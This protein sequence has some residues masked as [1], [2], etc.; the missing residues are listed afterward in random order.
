MTESVD[1][2]ATADGG[3]A[4]RAAESSSS[5]TGVEAMETAS[6]RRAILVVLVTIGLCVAAA[7]LVQ[8]HVSHWLK[9]RG[10]YRNL[11]HQDENERVEA[12]R[13]LINNGEN[14][15]QA[16][17]ALLSHSNAEVRLFAAYSLAR[18]RPVTN[19][20]IDL[21]LTDLE[22][23]SPSEAIEKFAT[24]LFYRHA[25]Q[26]T[27]PLT[28]TEQRMIAWLRRQLPPNDPDG[29]SAATAF[30][31]AT[32]LQRDPTLMK[33]LQDYL[34][35]AEIRS[36]ISV[37]RQMAKYDPAFQDEYVEVLLNGA[38]QS[39]NGNA[40]IVSIDYLKQLQKESADFVPGLETRRAMTS[41]PQEAS[42]LD[43]A[44]ELLNQSADHEK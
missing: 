36:Q 21:F 10:A 27:G 38:S 14:P 32:F 1:A 20:T 33:P 44:I 22:S 26:A 11:S 31:L 37:A 12:V 15:D 17:I 28:P 23:E 4:F 19:R 30:S 8:P 24:N 34:K 18:R 41:D 35:G 43:R 7:I 39:V 25:E 42:R 16:L 5:P 40:R 9:A 13:W 6:R 29:R 3:A 2:P